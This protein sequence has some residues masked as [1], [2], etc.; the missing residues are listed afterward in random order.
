MPGLWPD[1]REVSFKKI[2]PRRIRAGRVVASKLKKE[3]F[4]ANDFPD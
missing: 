1:T 3:K 4:Y 2:D